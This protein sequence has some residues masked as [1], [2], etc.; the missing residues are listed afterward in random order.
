MLDIHLLGNFY[1][2][3]RGQPIGWGASRGV[4]LLLAAM[5]LVPDHK[6]ERFRLAEMLWPASYEDQARTNLRK[7]IYQLKT[8]VPDCEQVFDLDG[9]R[10]GLRDPHQWRVDV[11]EF[12]ACAS[13]GSL[14]AQ[15]RALDLYRGDLL[16]REELNGLEVERERLRNLHART[17]EAVLDEVMARGDWE[18]ARHIAQRAV[19]ADPLRESH[20]R[21]LFLTLGYLRDIPA[22]QASFRRARSL[23]GRETGLELSPET[24]ESYVQARKLAQRA[25]ANPLVSRTAAVP[26]YLSRP[27]LLQVF[28]DWLTADGGIF[29]L[30]GPGGSGKSMLMRCYLEAS[31]EA[32]YFTLFLDGRD[33]ASP[34]GLIAA[35]PCEKA[36][37]PWQWL[38]HLASPVL[39]FMDSARAL[40]PLA[41]F[42]A[43]QW[44]PRLYPKAR[45]VIASRGRLTDYWPLDNSWR[46]SVRELRVAD[47]SAREV[48]RYL[49]MRGI[50]DAATIRALLDN[51]GGHPLGLSLA[52]D[53]LTQ[54]SVPVLTGPEVWSGTMSKLAQHMLRE[55]EN[56]W[57]RQVLQGSAVVEEVNEELMDRFAQVLEV[58]KAVR[59]ELFGQLKFFSAL[60][61]GEGGLRW[62]GEAR[63]F[64]AADLRWRSPALYRK[65][66]AVAWEY[67]RQL[68]QAQRAGRE[69]LLTAALFLLENGFLRELLF[70]GDIQQ[71]WVLRPG[72][73][74]D[75]AA[76]ME[77][78]SQWITLCD[79]YPPQKDRLKALL[80]VLGQEKVRWR[81]LWSQQALVGFTASLPL[82]QETRDLLEAN[83]EV[84]TVVNWYSTQLAPRDKDVIVP[85]SCI[86]S[87]YTA[88]DPELG[89]PATAPL[90]RDFTTLLALEGRYLASSAHPHWQRCL[91]ALGFSEIPPSGES[92]GQQDTGCRH[93]LLDVA[94]T[95]LVG[96]LEQRLS[97]S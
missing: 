53:F 43:E 94:K 13:A 76:C 46:S 37:D 28:R 61:P 40:G 33:V 3:W 10:I 38:A 34:Q 64:L 70:P 59:Q 79:G 60:I 30:W 56:S 17:V 62:H 82:C 11:Q 67:Y 52:A 4:R 97:A 73:A 1:W 45:V 31:Q 88:V 18:E 93:Y 49:Q 39:L 86:V 26:Y 92:Y 96:W 77:L 63:R 22:L 78:W 24:V 87:A 8:A 54:P 27:H 71:D 2:L 14:D 68:L 29:N 35:L 74:G 65:L 6:L 48:H 55:V 66:K 81:T 90:L 19:A 58:P 41:A 69:R 47:W 7:I 50:T 72:R 44:L 95:G 25:T 21:R 57:H 16:A 75:V 5:A 80:L 12:L 83:P 42:F 89:R 91:E 84:G 36:S 23:L 32:G 15:R 20:W 51:F 85:P 9:P